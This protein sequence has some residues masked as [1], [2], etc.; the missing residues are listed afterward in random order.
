M[1]THELT[2]FI[3]EFDNT[4]IDTL[5]HIL[6]SNNPAISPPTAA[7]L[8]IANSIAALPINKGG[9]GHT[10]LTTKAPALFLATIIAIR[11]DKA[12]ART[13]HTLTK[14]V[15]T[16]HA[17]V[18]SNSNTR[19]DE[20][21]PRTPL[22]TLLPRIPADIL[23]EQDVRTRSRNKPKERLRPASVLINCAH[24]HNLTQLQTNIASSNNDIDAHHMLSTTLAS[25]KSRIF[26][27]DLSD[28]RTHHPRD[29]FITIARQHL[30]LPLAYLHTPH[31]AHNLN[32]SEPLEVCHAPHFHG[33]HIQYIEP[34]NGHHCPT[35]AEAICQGHNAIR[36]TVAEML[37]EAGGT[38]HIE[39][40]NTKLF[41][42]AYTKEQFRAM[43]PARPTGRTTALTSAL[44]QIITLKIPE[45]KSQQELQHLTRATHWLAT[46]IHNLSDDDH[47]KGLRVDI[48]AISPAG[49]QLWIDVGTI[50]TA[51]KTYRAS[52]LK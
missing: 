19:P 44:R 46:H 36:N 23:P 27:T 5:H 43:F 13:A 10:R 15:E 6:H 32:H 49:R 52:T 4:N 37:K 12:F 22:G 47:H 9:M 7:R 29:L 18:L 31:V 42:N 34:N 25:Q 39:P 20:L 50:N 28:R 30:G 3:T 45:A 40:C 38:C 51:T 16:A 21:D 33:P 35:Q 24:D 14:A 2:N 41:G 8:N 17:Q 48:A 1:P 11:N 26:A